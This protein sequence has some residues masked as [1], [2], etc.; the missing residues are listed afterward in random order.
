M[1]I[2]WKVHIDSYTH[3]TPSG[4]GEESEDRQPGHHDRV[5]RPYSGEN[6]CHTSPFNSSACGSAHNLVHAAQF[7]QLCC[8]RDACTRLE[9]RRKI[10]AYTTSCLG[11]FTDYTHRQSLPLFSHESRTNNS[12]FSTE[13]PVTPTGLSV[14][15]ELAVVRVSNKARF[16][17]HCLTYTI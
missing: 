6:A 16:L 3:G 17:H 11:P 1:R 2:N 4:F 7:A 12:S 9:S 8:Y 14:G 10:C 15:E 13:P 5:R